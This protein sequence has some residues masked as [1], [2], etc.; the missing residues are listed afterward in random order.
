MVRRI[1]RALKPGGVFLCQF[2]MDTQSQLTGPGRIMR[3]LIAAATFG[4][5]EY[6]QGDMLWLNIEF[7]HAFPSEEA[8]RAELEE[9]GL[10]VVS[11]TRDPRIPVR[12][13]AVCRK[14]F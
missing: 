2:R 9:G 5:L 13:G 11:I 8:V 7:L 4:N 1:A 10:S 6:E 3:R 12:G 14:S